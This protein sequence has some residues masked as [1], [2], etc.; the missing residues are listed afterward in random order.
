MEVLKL[1]TEQIAINVRSTRMILGYKTDE[2]FA[3]K[4]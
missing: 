1:T 3:K 4:L 2:E